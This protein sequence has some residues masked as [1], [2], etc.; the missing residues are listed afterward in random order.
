MHKSQEDG[1]EG[2]DD[3]VPAWRQQQLAEVEMQRKREL[4][5]SE[6]SSTSRA[7]HRAL[8]KDKASVACKAEVEALVEHLRQPA[9]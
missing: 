4:G 5:G 1:D 3:R 6:S 2:C 7:M 8:Q 9:I